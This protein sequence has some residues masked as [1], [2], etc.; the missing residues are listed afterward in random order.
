MSG[1]GDLI[2]ELKED[3]EVVFEESL[4][5]RDFI[6]AQ[7][8]EVERL[9]EEVQSLRQELEN[10]RF[11]AETT[12]EAKDFIIE[13]LTKERVSLLDLDEMSLSLS[14]KE[15]RLTNTKRIPQELR[16]EIKDIFLARRAKIDTLSKEKSQL[17]NERI[18]WIQESK[19]EYARRKEEEKDFHAEKQTTRRLSAEVDR[20]RDTIK[21][22][23]E[24]LERLLEESKSEVNEAPKADRK[25]SVTRKKG[26]KYSS[27]QLLN[28]QFDAF[29]TKYEVHGYMC[30]RIR[31]SEKFNSKIRVL[32]VN[33]VRSICILDEFGFIEIPMAEVSI[34]EDPFLNNRFSIAFGDN[35]IDFEADNRFWIV[36]VLSKAIQTS[37]VKPRLKSL[38]DEFG[39]RGY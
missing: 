20:H 24:Q 37:Q 27:C 4:K 31:E 2:A 16:D 35:V 38:F 29:I 15:E 32:C 9:N 1:E 13:T 17:M 3:L 5:L 7:D 39:D 33:G 8:E 28:D 6:R 30:Y 21:D 22:L 25:G 18:E 14:D 11:Y 10:L 36:K 23:Q 34:S 26:K 12:I 19:H